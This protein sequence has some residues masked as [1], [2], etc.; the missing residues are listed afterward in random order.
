MS[1]DLR[2]EYL[3]L[4]LRSPLVASA[5]PVTRSL[6][7]LRLLEDAGVGAV[8]LPSLFEE[9]LIA[10]SLHVDTLLG[11]LGA[12]FAEAD[13][14][15]GEEIAFATGPSEYLELVSGAKAA[16]S[17]PVIASLNGITPAGWTHYAT[18]LQEAGADA[19]EVNEYRVAADSGRSGADVEAEVLAVLDAVR[20]A[21][22]IPIAVKLGPYFSSLPHLAR[23]L[24]EEGAAGLV[25]F[26]RF[27]QPDLDL[28][29]LHATPHLVLSTSEE[30]RL[31]LRW[32]GL[33]RH[34]V[35]CSLA[36]STGVHTAAD[37]VKAILVGADVVMTT[38]ALL[39]HG[40]G[41]IATLEAGI[42]EWFEEHEYASV[43]EA[44]GSAAW[45]TGPD[46]TAF[47]RA[48]YLSV[49]TSLR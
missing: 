16:L 41:H 39:H 21:V 3:G 45:S 48:N 40:P 38:S 12:G 9:Q 6:D 10:E 30:L 8:V 28:T 49:L 27:Y 35:N 5:G 19:L 14:F 32:I 13:G 47:E 18:L 15:F 42:C 2:T 44:R 29:T 24:A 11:D 26:N 34:Q 37:V 20:S 1:I 46:P 25:L 23:Q 4:S 22:D 7:K 43:A 17:V 36:L 33:L 31:P